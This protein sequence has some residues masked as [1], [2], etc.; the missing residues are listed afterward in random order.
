VL[1]MADTN[2]TE[3]P[4]D[5]LAL[6]VGGLFILALVFATYNYFNKN[7]TSQAEKIALE[8]IFEEEKG[9]ETEGESGTTGTTATTVAAGDLNGS[10]AKTTATG[11]TA[12]TV[13]A[14][15]VAKTTT[16]TAENPDLSWQANNYSKGDIVGNSYTV[17]SGDTLWEIAEGVYGDGSQWVKIL[18]AN[19]SSIG[20]L[21]NGQQALIRSGQVLVLP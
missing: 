4:K 16:T 14:G 3:N 11:S 5:G 17:K 1:L 10:G 12:T 13:T 8:K 2:K 9:N 19:K 7:K 6:V 21:A 18:N 20:L 15:T